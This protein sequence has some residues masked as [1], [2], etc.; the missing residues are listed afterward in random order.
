IQRRQQIIQSAI[1]YGTRTEQ[2]MKLDDNSDITQFTEFVPGTSGQFGDVYLR[3]GETQ[4]QHGFFGDTTTQTTTYHDQN[5]QQ[6]GVVKS[7]IDGGKETITKVVEF[8][9]GSIAL[10][11]G[12]TRFVPD[13]PLTT[14]A[15][16]A[17]S[18]WD[19]Q[20]DGSYGR[21]GGVSGDTSTGFTS[22]TSV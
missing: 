11:V 5:G 16:K 9:P 15:G 6:I 8:V 12:D 19:P 4:T 22:S 20:T 18:T 3:T 13:S 1:Q 2:T 7:V 21:T 17:P 14:P 10:Q